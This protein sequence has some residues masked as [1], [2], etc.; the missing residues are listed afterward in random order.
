[1]IPQFIMKRMLDKGFVPIRVAFQG[2][3]EYH[4][5]IRRCIERHVSTIIR[6]RKCFVSRFGQKCGTVETMFV[7]TNEDTIFC[8]IDDKLLREVALNLDRAIYAVPICVLDTDKKCISN[9]TGFAIKIIPSHPEV[10]AY[11][12]LIADIPTYTATVEDIYKE[13]EK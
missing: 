10:A 2:P 8:D 3:E 7:D 9:F 11:K 12:D 5:L 6:A 4:E 13:N 1:M